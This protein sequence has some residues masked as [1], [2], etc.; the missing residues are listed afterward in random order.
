MNTTNTSLDIL[1]QYLHEVHFTD[2]RLTDATLKDFLND[3]FTQYFIFLG[4]PFDGR[5][6]VRQSIE[7]VKK[8]REESDDNVIAYLKSKAFEDYAKGVMAKYK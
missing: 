7:L 1:N 5:G 3:L 4:S 2:G 6:F 8:H